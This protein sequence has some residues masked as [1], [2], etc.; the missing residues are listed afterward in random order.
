MTLIKEC[1]F[2]DIKEHYETL[3]TDLIKM[4]YLESVLKTAGISMDVKKF[5]F[6]TLAELYNK[7]LMFEKAARA[8]YGKA[9][10]DITYRE[11]I[12]SYL[13]AAEFFVKAGNIPSADDMFLRA[14]RE[15]NTEQQQKIAL[16]KK[17]IYLA[18]AMEQEKKGRMA[19]SSKFYTHLLTLK[20]DDI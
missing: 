1:G 7:R 2:H 8:M 17:N 18:A 14:M 10:F 3:K 15:A 9:W 5:A 11:K 6:S 16:A 20:L 19:N 13:R 12:D 4:E